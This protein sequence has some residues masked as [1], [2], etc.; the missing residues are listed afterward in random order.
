MATTVQRIT[1]NFAI[2]AAAQVCANLLALVVML[3]LARTL[4][5]GDFGLVN[6]ALA[7]LAYFMLIPNA[8]LPLL[9]TREVAR[10]EAR[11]KDYASTILTL[12]LTLSAVSFCLLLLLAAVL[13]QPLETKY[14]LALY[15][16]CLLPT[17]FFFDWVFQ[18][19]QRMEFIG[20]AR[21]LQWALYLGLILGLVKGSEQLLAVPL[22]YFGGISVAALFLLVLFIR[23]FGR[24]SFRIDLRIWKDLLKQALPMGF[25]FF[26]VM[27]YT[28]FDTIMLQFMR[29]G[30]EVGYY[31]AAYKIILFLTGLGSLYYTAIFP[32]LSSLYKTSLEAMRRL[33]SATAKLAVILVLPL[34]VGGT[35]LARPIMNLLYGNRYDGGIIALQILIWVVAVILVSS[36]YG[37]SLIASDRQNRFALALGVGAGVNLILNLALIP[38]YGLMGAAIATLVTEVVVFSLVYRYFSQIVSIP[39]RGRLLRPALACVGMAAFL[40]FCPSWNVILLTALGAALYFALLFLLGGIERRE[41]YLV[42]EQLVPRRGSHG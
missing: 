34:A 40:Y 9:G 18:G 11:I 26:M 6:F 27:L 22:L 15:G 23:R 16:L 21:V 5:V 2:L 39:L 42:W 30:E 17:A 32:P 28:N 12:R 13:N 36:M 7:V 25:S 33:L 19:I 41:I 29:G 10:D 4:A 20:A 3:Y 1:K 14:L 35:I 24:P 37:L 31:N 38:L 8:G